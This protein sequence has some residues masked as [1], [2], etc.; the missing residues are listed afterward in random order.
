M[1]HGVVKPFCYIWISGEHGGCEFVCVFLM[2]VGF[3][4]YDECSVMV[5]YG[6]FGVLQEDGICGMDWEG[7][8]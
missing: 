5:F 3:E 4:V 7:G 1:N 8:G 2:Y 6:D